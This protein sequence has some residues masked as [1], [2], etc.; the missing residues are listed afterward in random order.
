M[1]LHKSVQREADSVIRPE[2]SLDNLCRVRR[3]RIPS[4][5]NI[6]KE[7]IFSWSAGYLRERVCNSQMFLDDIL[8]TAPKIGAFSSSKWDDGSD[9]ISE[10]GIFFEMSRMIII[11]TRNSHEVAEQ[12]LQISLS[13]SNFRASTKKL[14]STR[15]RTRV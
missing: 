4:G 9:S 3:R 14:V 2:S 7:G 13:N 8:S 6:G 10:T 12:S 11:I 5:E 15:A 1:S